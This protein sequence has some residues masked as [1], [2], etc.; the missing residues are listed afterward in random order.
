MQKTTTLNIRVNP[1]DKQA[2]EA[3]LEKLGIPMSTAITMFLKKVAMSGG[4]PFSMRL[5]EAPPEMD[6]SLMTEEEIH[7]SLDI[8]YQH[9]L[10][11]DVIDISELRAAM[12]TAS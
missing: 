6:A 10:A 9:Y 11:G 3:I 2:A 4:I 5:P 1:E 7:R 8:G 12:E